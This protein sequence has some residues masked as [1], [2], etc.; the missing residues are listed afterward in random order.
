MCGWLGRAWC[1][2]IEGEL[3]T[4]HRAPRSAA[5]SRPCPGRTQAGYSRPCRTCQSSRPLCSHLSPM[6]QGSSAQQTVGSSATFL[7]CLQSLR[8]KHQTQTRELSGWWVVELPAPLL[9]AKQRSGSGTQPLHGGGRQAVQ[10][11]HG[12]PASLGE[13][14]CARAPP[15][16]MRRGGWSSLPLLPARLSQ[17]QVQSSEQTWCREHSLSVRPPAQN[18]AT[19]N[20]AQ[21]SA[22]ISHPNQGGCD[23]FLNC[24]VFEK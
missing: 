1:S 15:H 20:V 3:C 17:Y 18:N 24:A 13:R 7:P 11:R 21:I 22:R 19:T 4:T 5:A 23:S 16:P 2:H 12:H 8:Q 9:L 6:T 14:G 10:C